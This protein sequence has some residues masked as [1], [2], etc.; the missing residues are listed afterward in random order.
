MLAIIRNI[1]F[2]ISVLLSTILALPIIV[3]RPFNPANSYIFQVILNR[4]GFPFMG[5]DFS[6]EGQDI[7]K[8]NMPAI[9]IGNHQHNF[10]TFLY[11]KS[12]IPRMVSVGKLEIALLPIFG[13]AFWL[14]GNIL[15]NRKN[16]KSALQSM[17]QVDEYIK[18]KKVSVI[19]FPEGTRNPGKG[20][21]PFKKG[22]FYAAINSQVP[23]ICYSVSN[24]ARHLQLNK[25]TSCYM[26]VKVHP[27]IPTEGMTEKDIPE[28]MEKCRKVI[29]D[30][31]FELDQKVGYQ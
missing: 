16:K 6:I 19:I 15:I 24:Y 14:A 12:F 23:L 21:L 27:P 2:P 10:D 31:I 4:I 11:T 3:L 28:L 22:A 25:S 26:H 18:R 30:G 9:A 13:Q 7:F 17:Q 8:E 5:I 20:L 29:A 1:Y